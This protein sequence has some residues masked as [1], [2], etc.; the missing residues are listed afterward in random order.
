MT[1]LLLAFLAGLLTILSPCVLPLAPIV[2]AG[3]R[4]KSVLGPLALA[5][6][7]A[8]TFGIVGGSLASFSIELGETGSVRLVAAVLMIAVGI[9]MLV[10]GLGLKTE[11]L[12]GPLSD[13]GERLSSRF[14]NA[15]LLGQF[16]AG[17]VLAFVWAPCVGPTLGAAFALAAGGGSLAAAILIM[18]VFALGSAASLIVAGY[19]LGKMA[20][21]SRLLAQKSARIGK[22]ALASALICIGVLI[23]SGLDKT[24]EAHL[25]EAMP[26]WLVSAATRL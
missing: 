12:F 16:C 26:D 4:A 14:P 19:G 17:I 22:A 24:V 20:A 5:S 8:I 7:L 13:I 3:A 25:V 10:P 1:T 18:A 15:G 21:A 9:V 11:S 6:G 2:I 23:V